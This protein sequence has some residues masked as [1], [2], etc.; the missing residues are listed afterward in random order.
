MNVYLLI[1]QYIIYNKSTNNDMEI[2]LNAIHNIGNG[3]FILSTFL[4]NELIVCIIYVSI[5]QS[6]QSFKN[7]MYIFVRENLKEAHKYKL[8]HI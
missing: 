7:V 5:N 3:F 2:L 1:S 6:L 8:T 4:Q